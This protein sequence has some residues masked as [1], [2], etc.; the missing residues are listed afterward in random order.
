MSGTEWFDY[1][2]FDLDPKGAPVGNLLNVARLMKKALGELNVTG[3]VKTSGSSGIH[4]FIPIKRVYAFE[5]IM[6]WAELVTK[7]VGAR[8][9]KIAT[10]KRRLDHR[11]NAQ[12]YI[13]RQQSARGRSI[14][15]PCAARAT[16]RRRRSPGP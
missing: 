6:A 13:N 4:I 9:C 14:T 12:I 3:F 2:V 10:V 7:Q 1:V 5:R 15:A 11:E 8:N 16:N